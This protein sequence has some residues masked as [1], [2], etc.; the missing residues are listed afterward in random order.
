M[1]GF[2]EVSVGGGLMLVVN[3]EE[4]EIIG[5]LRGFGLCQYEARMYFTL[6][7]LGEAQISRISKKASVPQSRAYAVLDDLNDKDFV[8]MREK[9]PKQYQARSLMQVTKIRIRE[10][11][12]E[13]REL[14]KGQRRL[15]KILQSI[16]PAHTNFYGLRLFLPSY[17]G[18]RFMA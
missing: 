6:L 17:Q 9:R 12:K 13:I 15:D 7:V 3:G 11:Q 8:E 18:R 5:M 14:E 2:L 1:A 4:R 16:R 10:K